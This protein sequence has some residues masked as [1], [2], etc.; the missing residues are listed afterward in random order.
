MIQGLVYLAFLLM[1]IVKVVEGFVRLFG[2]VPFNKSTHS[3]DSGVLGALSQAGCCGERKSKGDRRR[4]R[5]KSSTSGRQSPHS[6]LPSPMA[7]TGDKHPSPVHHSNPPSFLRPEQALLPYR[8]D[9]DDESGY[10]MG[11]WA[12]SYP[13]QAQ[14]GYQPVNTFADTSDASLTSSG[15]ARVG[16]GR[17]NIDSPFAIA[18]R[19]HAQSPRTRDR[20]AS[21]SPPLPPGAMPASP[22]HMRSQSHVAI[23]ENA[24]PGSPFGRHPLHESISGGP[25]DPPVPPR[26]ITDDADSSGGSNNAQ[27]KRGGFWHRK[28]FS[29]PAKEATDEDDELSP[30]TPKTGWFSRSKNRTDSDVEVPVKKPEGSSFVVV[31]NKKPSQRPAQKAPE[32]PAEGAVPSKSFVVVRPQRNANPSASS[33]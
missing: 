13:P 32:P 10:I 23:I 4:R 27:P 8:E 6:I 1:L 25:H 14:P 3:M 16:G 9:A 22:K 33:S 31:R 15:F 11:A 5:E 2:R 7:G 30:D 29:Q 24:R 26:I 17:A 20:V 19:D 18:P 21:S 28:V 12:T